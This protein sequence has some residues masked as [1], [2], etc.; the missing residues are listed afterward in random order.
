MNG[1]R[2]QRHQWTPAQIAQLRKK[3]PHMQT[4][5]VAAQ[6][7]LSLSTVNNK[8]YHLHLRK[9][10]EYLASGAACRRN[11]YEPG[12]IATRFKKGLTPHNKGLRRPGWGPGRMKQTQFKP[13]NRSGK[14]QQIYKPIGSVR[15]S[16]DGIRQR[17]IHNGLPRQSRWKAVHCLL[18]EH[19]HGPVPRGH[20]IVFINHKRH[21]I[22]I[23][24][25]E[26]VSRSQ[27]MARNSVHNLPAPLPQLIQLRAAIK[28][29]ITRKQ[30]KRPHENQDHRPA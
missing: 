17:K 11:G 2:R 3:F 4:A 10:P 1:A 6:L 29:Q 21:D 12:S 19:H 30:R 8:A 9:T 15:I 25:L 5:K 14:A 18:W 24:N 27:L 26:C 16:K 20:V 23:D 22:R 7:G 13:G 28:A